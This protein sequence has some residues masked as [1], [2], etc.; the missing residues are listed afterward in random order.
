MLIFL[1]YIADQRKRSFSL[2]KTKLTLAGTEGLMH[3]L[4]FSENNFRANGSADRHEIWYTCL[5]IEQFYIFP[6]NFKTVPTMTFEHGAFHGRSTKIL[7]S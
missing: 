4:G 1:Q 6:E 5:I 7:S 3:P 2:V